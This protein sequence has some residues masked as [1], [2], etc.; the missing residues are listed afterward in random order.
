MTFQD[1]GLLEGAEQ[2]D[3]FRRLNDFFSSASMPA[4]STPYFFPEGET[5]A[6]PEEF[7]M[8]G[9]T[10][11]TAKLLEETR[12]SSLVVLKDG[13][14]VFENYWLTGAVDVPWMSWSMS[15]SMI[16]YLLGVA[17]KEG[18]ISSILDPITEY[19]PSL[20]GS[21]YDNV[22]IRDVLEMSSGVRWLEDYSNYEE[23]FGSFLNAMTP[24]GSF[25]KEL[26]ATTSQYR[27]GTVCRYSSADTQAL[28]S[29]LQA[30]TGESIARYMTSRL[31]EPLGFESPSYWITDS[32]GL[33]MALGGVNIIARD[34]AKFGELYRLGGNWHGRQLIPRDW[35][36]SSIRP[37]ADY[38]Q[39]GR[40][41]LGDDV[42][43]FGY[44]LQWWIAPGD[45]GEFAAVGIY[46]QFIYVNPTRGVVIVKLS[47]NPRFGLSR[48][49]SD[50]RELETFFF[51]K[52]VASSLSSN[53]R[54]EKS[55]A[56]TTL[57]L[58]GES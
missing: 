8:L 54:P 4:S 16:S 7:D 21:A 17:V 15:K 10:S 38:Q 35:V 5:Y 1:L 18:L 57:H 41:L 36:E 26:Q 29:L 31:I 40:V 56:E 43:P 20:L 46:N 52:A 47:A 6:L 39:C 2:Y 11:S 49:E 42:L 53:S 48:D 22:P 3:H 32:E 14:L 33:E 44:G 24:G 50:N 30:C 34:Y 58:R 25:I 12:T 28:G 13:R 23:S 27:P 37:R 19:V 51:F 45:E 55:T 9:N